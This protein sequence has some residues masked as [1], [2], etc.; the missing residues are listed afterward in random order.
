MPMRNIVGSGLTTN[1]HNISTAESGV[2]T[3]ANKAAPSVS[4][5]MPLCFR[6]KPTRQGS[7][8]RVANDVTNNQNMFVGGQ[9][10]PQSR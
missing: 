5:N 8:P 10:G 4:K 9:E 2:R 1:S 3:I 6:G 7:K